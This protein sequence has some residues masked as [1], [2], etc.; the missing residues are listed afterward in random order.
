MGFVALRGM[1]FG[2]LMAVWV[3]WEYVYSYLEIY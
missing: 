1:V 2:V 3:L